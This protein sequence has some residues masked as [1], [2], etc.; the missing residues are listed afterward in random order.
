MHRQLGWVLGLVLVFSAGVARGAVVDLGYDLIGNSVVS[1]AAGDILGNT[2]VAAA[3]FEATAMHV[4]VSDTTVATT[5]VVAA[6]YRVNN[7]GIPTTLLAQS[8]SPQVCSP[9]S[10]CD[11]SL[12]PAVA[13]NSGQYYYLCFN[14]DQTAVVANV[15]NSAQDVCVQKLAY[16]YNLGIFPASLGNTTVGS[17]QRFSMYVSGNVFTPTVTVTVTSTVTP[18]RTVTPTITPTLTQTP[19]LVPTTTSTLT[20]YV[21]GD[22]DVVAYP[23]PLK[24]SECRFYYWVPGPASV[25]IDVFNVAGER[26]AKVEDKPDAVGYHTTRWDIRNVA[27]GIYFYQVKIESE[28]GMRTLPLKK[29]AVVK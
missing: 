10:W 27:P 11:L 15:T 23:M 19:T 29:I 28:A 1:V 8:I 21:L 2:F 17:D 6:I 22:N 7:A 14:F 16:G 3:D 13:I 24:G 4:Y 20:P 25:T 5:N 18:T 12:P 26:S 9:G